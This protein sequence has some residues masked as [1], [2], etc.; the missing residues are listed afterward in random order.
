MSVVD[1]KTEKATRRRVLFICYLF[2]PVGGAGVQRPAKFVKYLQRFG[3]DV[4]VLT[5]ENPS[6]PVFD[7]SLLGDI[8]DATVIHRVRTLEPGYQF[9]AGLARPDGVAYSSEQRK[10]KAVSVLQGAK[11][12]LRS[13]AGT[14]LQP[15]PQILWFPAAYRKAMEVLRTTPHD[16]I[17]ATA[18][19]YSG[20]LLGS[21]LKRKTGLPLVLDYR[22]E[23]DL[24][25][26]Y[27]ENSKRDRISLFIQK[28]MQCNI[29]RS[30][31]GLIATTKASTRR[32]VERASEFGVDLPGICIYNGFDDADFS[33]IRNHSTEKQPNGRLRIV[34]TGTL[35]NLTTVEPLVK[36]I[37]Q[38]SKHQP[39]LMK[40]LQ[41]VFIGRKMSHQLAL[42]EKL[43]G[44][45]CQLD[46]RDYCEHEQAL[47]LMDS[48]DVLCLLLSD[49]D[50]AERVVPAK[51]FE[52]LAMRKEILAIT[53]KGETADIVTR[54]F[55]NNHFNGNDVSG[56]AA[57]IQKRL[58]SPENSFVREQKRI[59][60]RIDISEFSRESQARQLSKYF[61]QFVPGTAHVAGKRFGFG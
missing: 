29:L 51:L 35:W 46:I 50:G 61:A 16:I 12:V 28:R 10:E 11:R 30:A 1:H 15:D 58:D 48:A 38:L 45:G 14:I 57:W 18:P 59:D 60:S 25:S 36:A 9:K 34:Y 23:W 32:V 3:W 7:E 43:Q 8:P 22:D 24:S 27:L 20:F 42:L 2:P 37:M 6:V 5:V 31:N 39:E 44:T 49:V 56:I 13:V 33:A 19:P 26:A 55:S 47:S 4:T 41:L 21:W 40:K 52:Y 53:P 54:Y 17:F